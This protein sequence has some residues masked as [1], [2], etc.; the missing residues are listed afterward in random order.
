MS[1]P[2]VFYFSSPIL[3]DTYGIT[4]QDNLFST[5]VECV[6]YSDLARTQPIGHFHMFFNIKK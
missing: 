1:I 4:N 6:L 2:N 3:R 5:I